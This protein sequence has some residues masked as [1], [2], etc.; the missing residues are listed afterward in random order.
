MQSLQLS[1]LNDPRELWSYHYFWKQ[2]LPLLPGHYDH[3]FWG[4]WVRQACFQESAIQHAM[5]AVGAL[6][7][8]VA[9]TCAEDSWTAIRQQYFA[10]RQY[11]KAIKYLTSIAAPSPP[12]ENVLTCCIIFIMFENLYGRNGEASKHLK[13]GLAI[14]K[15]WKPRTSSE[16]AVK[17]EYLTP[18]YTR[19]Y[20][21]EAS[22]D[23]K[24]PF[25]NVEIARK[26]LQILLDS[27]YLSINYAVVSDQVVA[28][29]VKGLNAR[30]VLQQ[31]YTQFA[32]LQEPNDDE[33]C[34]AKILLRLQFETAVILLVSVHLED[35]CGFD[36]YIDNFRTI[37]SQCERLVALEGRLLGRDIGSPETFTYG[38]DLNIL[39]PLNITAFKCRDPGLRRKA[40]ALL[41]IGNRYEGLWNGKTVARIAQKTLEIEETGLARTSACTDIPRKNRVRLM[42]LSYVPDIL[43]STIR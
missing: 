2:V 30:R 14:L 32:A 3:L 22:V 27:I 15:S 28:V 40:I 33:S 1:I 37:V 7:E 42:T 23:M 43:D 26:N 4:T 9:S 38:F 17:T 29:D 36:E 35:E 18:I 34:R 25:G 41:N 31:W 8:S 24:T 10:I 21:R 20:N 5:I 19:G 12:T 39:P 13:S 11:N 6:H 16:L